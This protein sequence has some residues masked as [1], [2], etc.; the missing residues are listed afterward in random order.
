M[1]TVWAVVARE[2]I[3]QGNERPFSISLVPRNNLRYTTTEH[4]K[5]GD[6]QW[7]IGFC[8][9]N[10]CKKKVSGLLLSWLK[11]YL[12]KDID[13]DE[14]ML[15]NTLL[16]RLVFEGMHK[17]RIGRFAKR[18]PKKFDECLQGRISKAS[19]VDTLKN[20][21]YKEKSTLAGVSDIPEAWKA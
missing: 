20:V 14:R 10:P 2:T 17:M 5:L 1:S 13:L 21:V 6:V 9:S 11:R 18:L 12:P 16:P 4:F 8:Q 15:K 7:I 3:A 19:A